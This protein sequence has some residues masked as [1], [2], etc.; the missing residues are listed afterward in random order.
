MR[1]H[2]CPST[3]WRLGPWAVSHGARAGMDCSDGLLTD[4]P[5]LARESGVGITVELD[6]LPADPIY[7]DL[8]PLERAAGGED[9]GLL[10][11]VEPERREVFEG[12]GFSVLGQATSDH[13]VVWRLSGELIDPS[14]APRFRH[15]TRG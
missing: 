5:R 12:A 7:P 8:S 13:G 15:F 2:L 6:G 9:Y 1:A 14:T 10:V 4:V 11:L 3:S